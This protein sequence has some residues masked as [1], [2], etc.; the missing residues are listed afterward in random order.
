MQIAAAF[1]LAAVSA[2]GA[3]PKPEDAMTTFAARLGAVR[4]AAVAEPASLSEYLSDSGDDAAR[5]AWD[6]IVAEF[7]A[8]QLHAFFAGAN[9]ILGPVGAGNSK[10]SGVCALYNPWL[11]ALLAMRF[12]DSLRIDRVALVGGEA[13][14]GEPPAKVPPTATLVP[15]SDPH[16]VE[17][18]RVQERTVARFHELFPAGEGTTFDSRLLAAKRRG[19]AEIQARSAL[20]LK[21]LA[22][23]AELDDWGRKPGSSKMAKVAGRM[24]EILRRSNEAV[25]KRAF[26]APAHEFFCETFAALPRETRLGFGLYHVVPSKE[27]TLFVFLNPALPR[28]YATVSFPANR[29]NDPSA[30]PPVLE[31][32]DLA[33]AHDLLSAWDS[34]RAAPAR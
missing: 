12:D 32:Y 16:S 4:E 6:A 15:D 18:W 21:L 23:F 2:H 26:P 9:A 8:T 22:G 10:W 31:W 28:I 27:G 7:S 20:H 11:D 34:E 14:R 1:A 17:L 5:A 33:Q 29:E 25:V 24:R 19:H 13:F 30:P 3:E